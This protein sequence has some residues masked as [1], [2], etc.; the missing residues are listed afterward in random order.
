MQ[1]L[2]CTS[3][4]PVTG[5]TVDRI[6]PPVAQA[7]KVIIAVHAAGVNFP[8]VLIVQGKYQTR[9]ALPF[10][11]GSEAAGVILSTGK[12][13]TRFKAG[14]RVVAFTGTGAFA[15][16]VS[17]NEDQVFTLPEQIDFVTGAGVLITYGTAYHA[18]KDRGR[19]DPG[20]TLLVLGAAGGV[21]LAAVEIGASMGARVIACASTPQKLALAAEHGAVA[22]INY[23]QED[24]RS[25]AGELTGGKGPDVVFDPVGG[26]LNLAALKSIGWGG[27]L[28]VVGFA[29]GD[30][31]SIP[32][33]LLLLR[34]AAAVGLLWGNSLRADPR[35]HAE[36]LEQIMAWIAQG[37]IR[38][39]VEN[40]Y[41]LDEAT[42]AL[43][44]LEARRARGKLILK[45]K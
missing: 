31:Q 9:P 13:V 19:L 30:I 16:Q 29:G 11:P 10:V 2:L 17:V 3:F 42:Q 44:H 23:A 22:G 8:D 38:P 33:N 28:L 14:D 35:P 37:R 45:I 12:G 39:E 34:N 43:Q 7:G 1:A 21:G 40:V 41:P 4:A 6:D 27:R 26:D 32:A 15:E 18:L 36:N 5:L 20:E 24:L 25:R